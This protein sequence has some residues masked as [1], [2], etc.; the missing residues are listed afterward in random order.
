MARAAQKLIALI[1]PMPFRR[2]STLAMLRG[3]FRRP[4]AGYND[5][6]DFVAG[7][8]SR[9]GRWGCIVLNVGAT[10]VKEPALEQELRRLIACAA[11]V[12]VLLLSDLDDLD[13]ALE[14]LRC[15]VRGFVPASFESQ[16]AMA[17]LDLVQ[18][19]GTFFPPDALAQLTWGSREVQTDQE[20]RADQD[21]GWSLRQ[22]DVLR[23]LVEGHSN[24]VIARA[25][26]LREST[27]K[28][29]V[30]HITRKLG[31][32]NRTEA[33]LRAR[34]FRILQGGCPTHE[35]GSDLDDGSL[36]RTVGRHPPAPAPLPPPE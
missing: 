6:V 12:P 29:H 24:K 36:P 21:E 19:G 34:K 8:A 30:W 5:T 28:H 25:L 33:A 18:A 27:I 16:V 31:A 13:E 14:A 7:A 4:A 20:D 26:D 1:D 22:L 3:M 32:K 35:G 9:T 15:G 10:S 17:V 23:L 2:D 11:D